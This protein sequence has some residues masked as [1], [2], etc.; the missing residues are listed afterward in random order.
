VKNKALS[1]PDPDLGWLDNYS[2]ETTN[3]LLSLEGRYRIDSLVLVF[4]QAIDQKGAREG[5]QGLSPE[6][7]I[8]LAIEALEREVNNGGY[9]QFFLN[10]SREFASIIVEA[11]CRIGCRRTAAI[12][13]KALD[14]LN[15]SELTSEGIEKNIQEEDEDRDQALFVCDNQYFARAEDIE[16]HLFAFIKANKREIRL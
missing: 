14:A 10:S 9:E 13:Q 3:E 8:V 4:E 2:G 15:C 12:T 16:G 11:L 5:T 6:E 7:R 1:M